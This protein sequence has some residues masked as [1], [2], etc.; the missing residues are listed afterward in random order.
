MKVPNPGS[1]QAIAQGCK[2]P[3]IDNHY[4]QG[5]PRGDG[6]NFDFWMV[7]DC[8]LHGTKKEGE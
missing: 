8:P 2:C 3:V 6:V 7:E 4:G 1:K 5:V